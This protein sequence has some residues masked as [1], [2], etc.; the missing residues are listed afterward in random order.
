MEKKRKEIM[1]KEKRKK[2][3]RRRGSRIVE[4]K[5]DIK[6]VSLSYERERQ[7]GKRK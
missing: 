6:C 2:Q 4:G 7:K 3:R 1:R 5:G